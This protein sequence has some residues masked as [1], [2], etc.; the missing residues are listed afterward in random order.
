MLLGRALPHT[1]ALW[2]PPHVPPWGQPG[3]ILLPAA[4]GGCSEG[5][6]KR[7][8]L[9]LQ[10]DVPKVFWEDPSVAPGE[11][12]Q[13][14]LQGPHCLWL[15]E[16]SQPGLC[17]PALHCSPV[18]RLPGDV[19]HQCHRS[20]MCHKEMP[21]PGSTWVTCGTVESPPLEQGPGVPTDAPRPSPFPPA[22]RDS[23]VQCVCESWL[24]RAAELCLQCRFGPTVFSPG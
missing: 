6:S 9:W 14:H 22:P 5:Q 16:D 23:S 21:I 3:G 24:C 18:S 11:C 20:K 1:R 12:S 19:C 10:N 13:G 2:L 15:Q 7:T 8:P 17:S 4:P